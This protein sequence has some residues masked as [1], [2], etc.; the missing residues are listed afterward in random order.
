MGFTTRL[1]DSVKPYFSKI[2]SGILN[3]V[4]VRNIFV[5]L[6]ALSQY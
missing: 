1:F 5:T 2:R 4:I 3:N 6:Y